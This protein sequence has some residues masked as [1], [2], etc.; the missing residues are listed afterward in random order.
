MSESL[1][2]RLK[3]TPTFEEGYVY[4]VTR[5]VHLA[6]IKR[7]GLIAQDKSETNFSSKRNWFSP[8]LCQAF[9]LYGVDIVKA[10]YFFKSIVR[11]HDFAETYFQGIAV[12]RCRP[13]HLVSLGYATDLQSS[14]AGEK[15]VE[16]HD[17]QLFIDGKWTQLDNVYI[18]SSVWPSFYKLTKF[19]RKRP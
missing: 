19:L 3:M 14:L 6:S 5:G 17:M 10:R 18:G 11:S 1:P 15:M 16:P 9:R 13:A 8:D 12:L 7:H 2:A 4:H